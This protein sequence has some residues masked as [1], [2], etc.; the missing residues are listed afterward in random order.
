MIPPYSFCVELPLSRCLLRIELFFCKFLMSTQWARLVFFRAAR[1]GLKLSGKLERIRKQEI[2]ATSGHQVVEENEELP[3]ADVTSPK[4]SKSRKK[5]DT[6]EEI[7]ENPLCPSEDLETSNENK[8][9][10]KKRKKNAK[11]DEDRTDDTCIS[12]KKK[13]KTY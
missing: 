6:V 1:H 9:S 2:L 7:S 4:K 10:R 13:S 3:A 8:V 5:V 12:K 11:D